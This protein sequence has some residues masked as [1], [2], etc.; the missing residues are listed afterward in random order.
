MKWLSKR[1][2]ANFPR[3]EVTRWNP[4]EI[5]IE[6]LVAKGYSLLEATKIA[7]GDTV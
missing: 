5:Y 3:P 6:K 4:K 2:E 7:N 1:N